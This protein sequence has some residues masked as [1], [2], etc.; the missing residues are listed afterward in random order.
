MWQVKLQK[1]T[2][3]VANR[4]FAIQT[5]LQK[6]WLKMIINLLFL[7]TYKS[8]TRSANCDTLVAKSDRYNCKLWQVSLQI[9]TPLLQM[10]K[11]FFVIIKKQDQTQK[12]EL[13]PVMW[14]VKLQFVTKFL[15][16]RNSAFPLF[17]E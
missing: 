14:Q 6:H 9:V 7:N 12:P 16:N 11:R 17:S 10:K 15:H 4:F 1:V 5:F 2:G 8:D 3:I 13:P